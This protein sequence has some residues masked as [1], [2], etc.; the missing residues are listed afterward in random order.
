MLS[1]PAAAARSWTSMERFSAA[2]LCAAWPSSCA[3]VKTSR[4]LPVKFTITYGVMVGERVLQN[5]PSR[6]PG[7]MAESMWSS[8]KTP[9]GVAGKGGAEAFKRLE[10]HPDGPVVGVFFLGALGCRRVQ[11]VAPE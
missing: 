2:M 9:P 4:D 11:V 3:R 6:F 10:D 7:R 8:S 5:A 1:L